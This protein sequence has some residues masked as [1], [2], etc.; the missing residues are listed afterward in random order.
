MKKLLTPFFLFMGLL[1][2]AQPPEGAG[3]NLIPNPS[4]EQ[5]QGKRP[6]DDVDGSAAFKHNMVDWRSPTRTTPDLKIVLPTDVQK[7]KKSGAK[8]NDA[9]TGF[10]CI[11]IL[12]HNPNSE[13]S[14][15]YREYIQVKLIEPTK[16]G[17]DYYYEFWICRDALAKFASNNMGFALS[18]SPLGR[19]DS[20]EPLT[21]I[22]PD[23]NVTEIINKDKREWVKVS[24]IIKSANRSLYFVLG[25]FYNNE[26]TIMHEVKDG[27]HYENAYYWIDDVAL[28]EVHPEPEVAAIPEPE[29]EPEPEIKVGEVVKLDRVFFVTAKWD[30]LPESNTQLDEVVALL[31]KYPS[32]EIAINGH[33]DDRGDHDYNLTLS[34]NRAKSVFKYL[35]AQG[36]PKE[37]MKYVGYGETKPVADN[38]TTDGRQLNRRVEFIVT[39]I[40]SDN[41]E[42]KY[43][44]DVKPY[45]DND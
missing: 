35:V 5:V 26:K 10:K 7:A 12:T 21:D 11:A 28:H 6:D 42:I 13:R 38:A 8:Y 37:R 40:G 23:F 18:P 9:H 31:N 15:T 41:L 33:T 19:A 44:T 36:I 20:Y 1:S 45:T 27:G 24:G 22:Q 3:P 16:K 17:K 34:K 29:P 32:M 43:D 25:N 4:F 30:L 39:K 14:S 2:Y